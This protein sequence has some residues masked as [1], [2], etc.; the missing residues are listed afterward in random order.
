MD[1]SN[2][3]QQNQYAQDNLG[4]YPPQGTDVPIQQL[5]DPQRYVEGGTNNPTMYTAY[6]TEMIARTQTWWGWWWIR[7]FFMCLALGTLIGLASFNTNRLIRLH[8]GR[9]HHCDCCDDGNPCTDDICVLDGCQFLPK[10]TSV[11]CTNV[12]FHDPD[13][14]RCSGVDGQCVGYHCNGACDNSGDCPQIARAGGGNLQRI[15]G[16]GVCLYRDQ[17]ILPPFLP[18]VIFGL[19][20]FQEGSCNTRLMRDLCMRSIDPIDQHGSCLIADPRCTII[21]NDPIQNPQRTFDLKCIYYFD[22]HS[23]F[24]PFFALPGGES[25][26]TR[27]LEAEAW[28]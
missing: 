4:T 12:C 3:Q 6:P 14:H 15:C 18:A 28:S 16:A 9:F 27:T 2:N 23:T 22:C 17:A 21:S 5:I 11:Q 25:N 20:L 13:E 10:C 19:P 26:E 8:T 24:I 7:G 1:F